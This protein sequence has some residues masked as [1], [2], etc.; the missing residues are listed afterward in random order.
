MAIT[1][2][3]RVDFLI[4]DRLIIEVDGK[5]NH[6]SSSMRHKDLIRDANAAARDFVT[7]RF[8]YAMVVHDWP[9]V[10]SAILAQ[11][12]ADAT[13]GRPLCANTLPEQA[14]ARAS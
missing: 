8:D 10:E 12:A 6:A 1:A 7:L 2:V 9:L 3:G 5:P 14:T 13:S 4:G 11:V